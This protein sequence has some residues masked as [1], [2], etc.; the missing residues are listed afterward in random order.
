MMCVETKRKK[1][2]EFKKI[3]RTRDRYD[4]MTAGRGLNCEWKRRQR[5]GRKRRD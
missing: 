4:R 5:F 3:V 2:E 1:T